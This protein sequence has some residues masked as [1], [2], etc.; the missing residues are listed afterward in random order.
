MSAFNCENYQHKLNEIILREQTTKLNLS[1]ENDGSQIRKVQKETSISV[2]LL[3]WTHNESPD[4]PTPFCAFATKFPLRRKRDANL[5]AKSPAIC[6]ERDFS[7]IMGT[8][9]AERRSNCIALCMR[10][11]AYAMNE[12][13]TATKCPSC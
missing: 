8:V 7:D 12:T 3:L 6:T 11:Y 13:S 2:L 10:T 5:V 4:S 9:Y 1:P